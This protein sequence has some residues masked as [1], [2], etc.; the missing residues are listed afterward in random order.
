MGL[1]PVF[2]SAGP[3]FHAFIASPLSFFGLRLGDDAHG[4]EQSEPLGFVSVVCV[5]WLGCRIKSSLGSGGVFC[6]RRGRLGPS[7]RLMNSQ[8]NGLREAYHVL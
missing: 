8:T 4:E 5:D 6:P 1:W 7:L 3:L 2:P